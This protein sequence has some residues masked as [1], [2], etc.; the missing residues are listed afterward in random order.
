MKDLH[1]VHSKGSFKEFLVCSFMENEACS[2]GLHL[3]F[4]AVTIPEIVSIQCKNIKI[5]L[6]KYTGRSMSSENVGPW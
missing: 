2:V 3:E 5:F 4:T 6:S 1:P